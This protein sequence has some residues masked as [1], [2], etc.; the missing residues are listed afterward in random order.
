[1][2]ELNHAMALKWLLF[3][4]LALVVYVGIGLVDGISNGVTQMLRQIRTDITGHP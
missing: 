3:W 1:M 4:P 2:K